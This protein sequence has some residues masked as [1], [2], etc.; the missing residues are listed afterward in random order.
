MKNLILTIFFFSA[1][2]IVLPGPIHLDEL[3]WPRDIDIKKGVVTVYQPQIESFNGNKLEARAAMAVKFKDQSPVFGAMWF[4][5]RVVTDR[6]QHLVVFDEIDIESLKFPEGDEG[7]VEKLRKALTDKLSGMSLTMSLDRFTASIEHLENYQENDEGY[8]NTPPIV[9][10][11]TDPAVLVFIDGEP[12][13]KEIENSGFKYIMNTPYF[14]VQSIQANQYYLKGGK[15]WY[16]SSKITSGWKSIDNP[17]KEIIDLA[18]KAFQGETTDADS[19]TMEMDI[20]PKIIVS[21]A[22]SELIQTDGEPKFEP[23]SGTNLLFLTNSESDIIMDI[24]SQTYY[25]L[26]SGRWYASKSIENGGWSYVNP[27]ELPTD[28]EKI[29]EESDIADIRYSV[30]GTQEAKDAL[31]ENSIPQTAEVDRKNASVEVKI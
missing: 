14:L 24:N 23:V 18:E 20:P 8:K 28:F 22:P 27:D 26:L 7:N 9:Y 16:A 30:P 1:P 19:M 12:I 11:E 29:P 31:L 25:I 21:T 15:W 4:T 6:D 17:P 13:L 10:F 5:S 2:I 3:F